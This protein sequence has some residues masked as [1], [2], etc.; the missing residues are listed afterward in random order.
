[1]LG[2]ALPAD[3]M[4][5]LRTSNPAQRPL[6]AAIVDRLEADIPSGANVACF[7]EYRG[8]LEAR[9]SR[10]CCRAVV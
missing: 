1:M 8:F 3:F 7:D 6:F 2:G 9:A 5:C 4:D 10:A